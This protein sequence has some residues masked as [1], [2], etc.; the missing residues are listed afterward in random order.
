MPLDMNNGPWQADY[1]EATPEEWTEYLEK[2]GAEIGAGEV[3][4]SP[5]WPREEDGEAT[6]E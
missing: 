4:Y 1:S 5:G 2:Y 3:E 6:Q